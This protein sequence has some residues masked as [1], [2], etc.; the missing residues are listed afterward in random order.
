MLK[1]ADGPQRRELR[2]N[3]ANSL[4]NTGPKTAAGRAKSAP[5][6]FRHGLGIPV[7]SDSGLRREVE[8]MAGL[9]A[10]LPRTSVN[11]RWR[12]EIP[13]TLFDRTRRQDHHH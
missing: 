7:L 4:L 3:R 10:T 1:S 12:G 13:M 8:E 5:N 6:G 11:P 9:L 2:T